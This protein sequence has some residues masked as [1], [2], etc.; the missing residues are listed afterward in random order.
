VTFRILDASDAG[1]R[2]T[3]KQLHAGWAGR[4]V[5]ADPGYVE[6]FA[7]PGDQVLAAVGED[8]HG[9]VLYAFL[10]RPVAGGA[11]DLTSAY[12]YGGAFVV[13]GR[14]DAEAFWAQHAAWARA[15]GVV[16]EFVRFSLFDEELL[17]Y[18]GERQV[19]LTNVVCDLTRDDT[20][21]WEGFEHKVR[22]NVNRA[23][24]EGVTIELDP[25]GEH[26]DEFLRIYTGTMDRRDARRGFYFSRE[27][28]SSIVRE[29]PG[30]FMF[31][32][33]RHQ[34]RIIS[35]ELALV[36]AHNV[37]S[38]L[39]GT[40]ESAFDLRPN[41]LLKLELITWAR[42]AGKQ[43]FVLGGG[44]QPD[45]GIFKYKKAFAPTG[46]KPY[47][48]GTRILDPDRYA[49]LAAAHEQT[50]KKIDPTWTADPGFFPAYRT[51][52]PS[53]GPRES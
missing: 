12:G 43:R 51:E 18:P 14:P 25:A 40:E 35:T 4:E 5:F 45:D 3:W 49:A 34:G 27:L 26:L 10:S 13:S 44:Y 17:P 36:S 46:L 52:L 22:K 24:R 8:A 41:D 23:R 16:S 32:H 1:D 38:F 42:G 11:R 15:Q 33:A 28:F 30:Q 9:T 20:A 29:L 47:S 37:Y 7:G 53:S 31:F 21:I 6:R 48:I 2:A 39:G 19:K 50:A